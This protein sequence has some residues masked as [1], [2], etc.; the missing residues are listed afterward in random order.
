MLRSVRKK[1]ATSISKVDQVEDFHFRTW[2]R[3]PIT[4]SISTGTINSSIRDIPG[5]VYTINLPDLNEQTIGLNSA[6]ILPKFDYYFFEKVKS[7]TVFFSMN[8]AETMGIDLTGIQPK[9][10]G[11][12]AQNIE[13]GFS[14]NEVRDFKVRL[15][16][17]KPLEQNFRLI[18]PEVVD[19]LSTMVPEVI[20]IKLLKVEELEKSYKAV[21]VDKLEIEDIKKS[22]IKKISVPTIK[23]A[24]KIYKVKVPGLGKFESSVSQLKIELIKTPNISDK[25]L[26]Q[27]PQVSLLTGRIDFDQS[28]NYKYYD[29]RDEELSDVT[30]FKQKEFKDPRKIKNE[31]KQILTVVQK[32]EWKKRKEHQFKLLPY[33]EEGAEFLA[34]TDH[35][36]LIDEFGL[37]KQRE[38]LAALKFLF[39]NRTIKSALIICGT[40]KAGNIE[41]SR[42]CDLQI[43]WL[44]YLIK[45]CPELVISEINGSDDERADLWNKS[46]MVY[47]AEHRVVVNDFH[48]KIIDPK[49]FKQLDCIV[50]DEVHSIIGKGEKESEFLNHLN[51][52]TLWALSGLVEEKI[53]SELNLLLNKN[54]RIEAVKIRR[55]E[56]VK[57]KAP[58]FIWNENWIT[59]DDE[60]QREY[61]ETLVECQKDLRKVLETGN[62]YRFQANIFTLLHKLKQICNFGQGESGSPKKELLLEQVSMIKSNNKKVIIFSQYDRLGI[63]KIEKLFEDNGIDHILA[64]GSLSVDDMTKSIEKFRNSK[65]ITAFI[66]DAKISKLKFGSFNVPF[67]IKFDH[68]WNPIT[69]WELQDLFEFTSKAKDQ[70][71]SI[72]IYNV[73][74]TIDQDVTQ[75]LSKKGLLNKNLME[76]MQGKVFDELISVDEWLRFFNLVPTKDIVESQ[77]ESL[78]QLLVKSDQ[79]YFGTLVSKMLNKLG[80]AKID[81]INESSTGAFNIVGEAARNANSVF[82]FCKVVS[83]ELVSQATVS[84]IIKEAGSSKSKKIFVITKGRFEEDCEN[85]VNENVTL[86]DGLTLSNYILNFNMHE[87]PATEAVSD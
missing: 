55:K 80:Y 7:N 73:H 82:L 2:L 34:N 87:S 54:A 66:T 19:C 63:K 24:N 76:M 71:V 47:V 14:Y 39:S 28:L 81:I 75:L 59:L 65:D 52:R 57:D 41:L 18:T 22:K 17:Q 62:P 60:Q 64:P 50:L 49:K 8:P 30:D 46:A 12:V 3:V 26:L 58:Q 4:E 83:E 11:Y 36:L 27:F 9:P 44:G 70:N 43:G 35:A 61:K 1:V 40:G 56:D 25:S 78:L 53:E 32:V 72:Y 38:T 5:I 67:I 21:K 69:I 42:Q 79:N 86:I 16:L 23:K 51:P 48:M 29:V 13:F 20:N 77:P 31:L 10:Q 33:E 84:K 74:R 45:Y 37:N 6:N 15:D 85:I 68:W